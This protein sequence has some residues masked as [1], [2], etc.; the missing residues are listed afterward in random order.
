MDD[1]EL[2]ERRRSSPR[3]VANKKSSPLSIAWVTA[4][5]IVWVADGS[6]VTTIMN[7]FAGDSY[8]LPCP[9]AQFEVTDTGVFTSRDST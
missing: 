5:A 1:D 4:K 6:K 2:V 8:S 3:G 7:L 9:A